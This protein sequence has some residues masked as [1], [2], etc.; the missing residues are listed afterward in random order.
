M[1]RLLWIFSVHEEKAKVIME[2]S[3]YS[4]DI[5]ELLNVKPEKVCSQNT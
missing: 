2:I 3:T 1:P 4:P 5:S